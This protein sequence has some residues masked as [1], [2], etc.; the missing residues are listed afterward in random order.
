MA[1]GTGLFQYSY[2]PDSSRV[3]TIN[4]PNGQ[5]TNFSYYGN[6]GDNR[7]QEISNL[8]PSSSVL[9]QFNYGYDAEGDITSWQQSNSAVSG[10]QSFALSYD[11]ASQLVGATL[12]SGTNITSNI[13]GYDKDG[14]RTQLQVNSATTTSSYNS[15]NQLIGQ[16]AGGPTQFQ[17]TLSE[18]A[19]VTVGGS[20][21]TLISTV[22]GSGTSYSFDGAVNL[23]TGTNTV[24]IV[25]T[26]ASGNVATNNYQVVVPAGSGV[27]LSYDAD[28]EMTNNGAGQTYQWDAAGRLIAINYP[29]SGNQTQFTYNGLNQRVKIVETGSGA[30]TSSK[31]FVWGVGD[32]QP[33]EERDASDNV[34]RRFYPQGEQISGTNYY[35]TKDH[36]GSIH[37]LTNAAGAVQTQYSYDMWGAE[38]TLSGTL[39]A[40]FGYAGY[41]QH[42]PSGLNLAAYR[43]YSATL[44]RWIS[45]DPFGDSSMIILMGDGDG[46]IRPIHGSPRLVVEVTVGTNLYDYAQNDPVDKIDPLGLVA[47]GTGV[48]KS[49]GCLL[50]NCSKSDCKEDC[51]WG[52]LPFTAAAGY[53]F[54]AFGSAMMFGFSHTC[55]SGCDSCKNP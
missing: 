43:E 55:Q 27:T 39:N 22:T 6:T 50:H 4:Y 2:V 25:A 30:V 48:G 36:L 13:Y 16:S 51:F 31:Q 21:A 8:N 42:W 33:S 7:L 12:T 14:N 1:T 49:L 23:T 46:N 24:P 26:D 15:L 45:R 40:D 18:W 5:Q 44:G 10:T 19:N 47:P 32:A 35:Y 9:S 3:S 34:T 11:S 17:G 54:N 41:Y 38:T 29:G 53:F 52:Y 28:G 20:A 37:E